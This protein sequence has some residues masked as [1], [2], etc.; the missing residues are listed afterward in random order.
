MKAITYNP[1]ISKSRHR[2]ALDRYKRNLAF[3]SPLRRTLLRG[4]RHNNM[5]GFSRLFHLRKTKAEINGLTYDNEEAGAGFTR[6]P[7]F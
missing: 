7:E 4:S 6:P 1:V 2:N 3:K 5:G